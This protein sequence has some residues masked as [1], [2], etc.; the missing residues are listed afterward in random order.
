MITTAIALPYELARLP[1]VVVDRQLASRLPDTSFPRVVLDRTIGSADKLA[2][3]LLRNTDIAQRGVERIER[4]DKVRLAT[5]LE[6]DAAARRE[7]ARET[8]ATAERQGAQQRAAAADRVTSGLQEADA[9]E[10]RGKHQAKTQAAAS[11]SAKKAAAAKR[12]ATRTAT[13]EQRKGRVDAAAEAKKKAA[14]RQA[15]AELDDVRET[16]QEAAEARADA[17]RLGELVESKKAQRKS[18]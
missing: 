18:D 15:K 12:A 17:E 3:A 10:A 16:K 8:A 11:A 9:A 6:E 7:Q 5:Q 14:Q 4:S 2:G 1:L 13:V